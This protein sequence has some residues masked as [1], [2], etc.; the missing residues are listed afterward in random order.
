MQ[1]LGPKSIQM[2]LSPYVYSQVHIF[3]YVSLCLL[4]MVPQSGEQ[5][6]RH[7]LFCLQPVRLAV[8]AK[9]SL[10]LLRSISLLLAFPAKYCFPCRVGHEPSDSPNV[11]CR[12]YK[13]DYGSLSISRFLL[14]QIFIIV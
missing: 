2:Q 11:Y 7:F 10:L 3:V 14:S 4:A 6:W 5:R 8:A 9:F 12:K 13:I 1:N